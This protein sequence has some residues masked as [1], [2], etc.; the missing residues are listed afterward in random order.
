MNVQNIEAREE[1]SQTFKL[2]LFVNVVIDYKWLTIFAK[3]SI[4]DLWLVSEYASGISKVKCSSKVKVSL[5]RK[6]RT[7][8]KIKSKYCKK[9]VVSCTSMK[10]LIWLNSWNS[11]PEI[12]HRVA[13]LKFLRNYAWWR[14]LLSS[15]QLAVWNVPEDKLYHRYF[16]SNSLKILTTPICLCGNCNQLPVK[17]LRGNSWPR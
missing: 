16:L 14:P 4:L 2:E 5:W 15:V 8:T 10:K 9:G 13:V 17:L 6:V 3:S 1:P 11:C 12:F 7:Y